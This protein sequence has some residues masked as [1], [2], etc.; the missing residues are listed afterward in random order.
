MACRASLTIELWTRKKDYDVGFRFSDHM[1]LDYPWTVWGL[2][3]YRMKLSR[4]LRRTVNLCA[5]YSDCG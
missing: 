2:S 4:T 3:S 1:L 5:A